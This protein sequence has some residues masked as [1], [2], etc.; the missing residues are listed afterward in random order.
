LP[1]ERKVEKREIIIFTLYQF[2]FGKENKGEKEP[3]E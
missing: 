1:G 2:F 3:K